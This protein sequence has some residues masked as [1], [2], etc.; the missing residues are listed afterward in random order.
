MSAAVDH[1]GAHKLVKVLCRFE[2]ANGAVFEAG[3]TGR[4]QHIY[5]DWATS[6]ITIELVQGE[7]L[8]KIV[9]HQHSSKSSGP[10]SGNLRQ[11]FDV[12][13]EEVVWGPEEER[14]PVPIQPE[15]PL[16]VPVDMSPRLKPDEFS[17]MSDRLDRADQ[18]AEV[19]RIMKDSI[20]Y[21]QYALEI[22]TVYR[23]RWR[24]FKAAGEVVRAE[25]ARKEASSWAYTFAGFATSGGEGA[26]FSYERDQ[27]LKTLK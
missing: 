5:F 3:E 1:L 12:T 4:I 26:A 18:M 15:E 21:A 16:P 25:E 24:R 2:D 17:Q 11:Y 22:A 20:P 9:L 6:V 19:E 13:G 7:D 10:R 14:P 27:F 8:K 23:G